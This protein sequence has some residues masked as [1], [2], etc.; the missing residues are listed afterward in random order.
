MDFMFKHSEGLTY[1]I[2]FVT[3]GMCLSI[4]K[5]YSAVVMFGQCISWCEGSVEN[6][7]L[8]IPVRAKIHN[9]KVL[10][11]LNC[12]DLLLVLESEFNHTDEL[13]EM[14]FKNELSDG[15]DDE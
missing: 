12:W 7:D 14:C 9:Y 1:R 3:E 8:S 11:N 6:L 4:F 2:H 10:A 5:S 15:S 13:V